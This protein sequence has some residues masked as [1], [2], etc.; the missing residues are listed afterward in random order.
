MTSVVTGFS[1]NPKKSWAGGKKSL[2]FKV[3]H[4]E[5]ILSWVEKLRF[6]K[7]NVYRIWKNR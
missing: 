3:R 7:I 6:Q 2:H 5:M 1:K 4:S